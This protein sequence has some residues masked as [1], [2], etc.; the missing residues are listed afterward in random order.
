MPEEVAFSR[1]DRGGDCLSPAGPGQHPGDDVAN[2]KK[3]RS[4]KDLFHALVTALDYQQPH[5]GRGKRHADVLGDVQ[6]LKAGRN[7]GKLGNHV[8]KVHQHQ[9]GH[10]EEGYPQA[11][12]FADEIA[13]PLAGNCAHAR[14]HLLHH[15]QGK[16]D[17][18]DA[19]EK[20]VSEMGARG[21]VGI[22]AAGIIVDIR[23]N[24]AR[25]YDCEQK[26][27]PGLPVL[28]PFHWALAYAIST[29]F[30]E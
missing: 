14:R 6:K 26:Q 4:H 5:H 18:K 2:V 21:R 24:K 23:G 8:G 7:P 19:P 11:I 9:G 20:L 28:E 17:R 3:R 25:A 29:D 16:S 15:D 12:F 13:E 30:A 1:H 27:G 22:D 10:H